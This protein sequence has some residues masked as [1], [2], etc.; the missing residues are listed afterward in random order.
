M[1]L[2][3]AVQQIEALD[4][5]ATIYAR[6]P[7]LPSSE[8]RLAVESSAEEEEAKAAGLRYFIEVFIAQEFLEDWRAGMKK[9]PSTQQCYDRLIEY[10]A[11]DA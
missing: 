9:S 6:Y 4:S 7:W 5:E 10:V 1:T 2:L 8:A 3:E 11:N